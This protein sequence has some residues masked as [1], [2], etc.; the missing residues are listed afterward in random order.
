[1]TR[2]S[3]RIFVLA[4]AASFAVALPAA[5]QDKGTLKIGGLATLEGVF[6]VPG[7]DGMRGIEAALKEANYTAGGYKLEFIKA[8]S[9]A[10]PDSALRAAR[11]LV[12]QDKVAILV[13][14]LSGSEGLALKDYAKTQSGTTFINGTSAAQDT[15]LRDPAPNFFRF[16]TEG[17]QWM[18]GL[19]NYVLKDKGWKRV[20]T[21]GEDYSF[22][23][24]Q[25]F[26]FALPYCEAG[27]KIVQRF[28]VPLGTKDYSSIIAAIPSDADAIWL[29]LGGGDAV[30]FLNQYQQAGGTTPLIGAS[31]T[32]DQSIINSKGRA[33][34][35]LKGTPAAG[36]QSDTY[37]SP[38]WKTWVKLYQD[39][40]PADQRFPTPGLFA[41]GYYIATKAMID[42]LNAV[43]GDLSDNQKALRAWL[44]NNPIDTPVGPIK[45]DQNRQAIAPNFVT[46]VVEGPDGN[47][48]NKLVKVT[49]PINQTLGMDREKFSR[50]ARS[51]QQPEMR[52]AA[53]IAGQ[54][55]PLP[56]GEV[57]MR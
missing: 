36:P 21:I 46:E 8:S 48:V 45:L 26:G 5:A 23:H 56:L 57:G 38:E 54:C 7:Q 30:N 33:R 40:F 20:V 15:T 27:G 28:W 43:K 2:L 3:R 18:Y 55:P 6:A 16:W 37:D 32:V 39:S 35:A 4:A 14:P 22:M 42:G 1:M 50:S 53:V 52:V 47:L 19:G 10:S 31:I 44:S 11:K 49:E 17:A 25:F 51:P 13:G 29:G 34:E 9:D 41:T 24:T 12:E